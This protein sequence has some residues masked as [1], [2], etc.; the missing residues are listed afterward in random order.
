MTIRPDD[1]NANVLTYIHELGESRF[2]GTISLKFEGGK[3]V[4]IR[5]EKNLKPS[6]LCT[7]L[8]GSRRQTNGNFNR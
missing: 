3:I 8:S 1:P 6:D 5:A 7:E 2:W 4:H